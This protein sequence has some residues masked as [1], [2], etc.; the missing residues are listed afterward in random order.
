MLENM[1]WLNKRQNHIVLGFS[2]ALLGIASAVFIF[3]SNAGLMSIAFISV[4]L[5]PYLNYLLR[6]EESIEIREEKFSLSGI[7]QDH[8]NIFRMYLMMFL[9]IFIA[10][11]AIQFLFPD[12]TIFQSQLQSAGF[13]GAAVGNLSY[14]DI[15]VNNLI[16]LLICF[17]LSLV[18]GA[19]S[20]VFLTWNAS[21]W[22][23][24]IGYAASQAG[25][26]VIAFT[27]ILAP[28]LPHLITEALAYL[29]A[30][31]VGGVLSKAIVIEGLDYEKI[32]H[33]MTDALILFS[34]AVILILVA[35]LIEIKIN[36]FIG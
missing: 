18:Y 26:P 28:I 5:V 6:T 4:L 25:S 11:A 1:T 12:Y 10:Y 3:P 29:S 31:I 2:Y 9:G 19:G 30:A 15:I 14:T 36:Y 17:A 8:K 22:G 16:V 34:G 21:I 13:T 35:G 24:V 7:W 23:A 27:G 32:K 33:V 20:I